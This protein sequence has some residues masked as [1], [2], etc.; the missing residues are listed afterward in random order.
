M[1]ILSQDLWPPQPAKTA[2]SGDPVPHNLL[3][4][5]TIFD[6]GDLRSRSDFAASHHFERLL[7]SHLGR[8]LSVTSLH[9]PAFREAQQIG[10]AFAEVVGQF[11]GALTKIVGAFAQ[12][13]G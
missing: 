8:W 1:F 12:V 3:C 6:A 5:G 13:V 9:H 7:A 10:S 4:E 2:R 11:G